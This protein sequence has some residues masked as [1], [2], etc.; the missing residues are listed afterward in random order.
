MVS[1]RSLFKNTLNMF[2]TINYI[3]LPHTFDSFM[4][5]TFMTFLYCSHQFLCSQT[6]K[7]LFDL[8]KYKFNWIEIWLIWNIIYVLKPVVSHCLLTLQ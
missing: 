3:N 6:L 2:N 8:T 7:S 4:N 1:I 5:Y